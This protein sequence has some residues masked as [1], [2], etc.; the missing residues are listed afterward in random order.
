[1]E[2]TK[3]IAINRAVDQDVVEKV[4]NHSLESLLRNS[5]ECKS[6]EITGF[7]TFYFKEKGVA[8]Y[9]VRFEKKIEKLKVHLGTLSN[10]TAIEN[11][12]RKIERNEK[13]LIELKRKYGME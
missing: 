1:M 2:I 12:S 7:G 4:I 9:I 10:K 6:L 11:L 5:K 13:E 8:N 3:R